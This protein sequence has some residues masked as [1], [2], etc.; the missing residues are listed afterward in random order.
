MGSSACLSSP[1]KR[2]SDGFSPT[3]LDKERRFGEAS[4]R[5]VFFKI[6]DPQLLRW[7]AAFLL[8]KASRGR[9][10]QCPGN[11]FALARSFLEVSPGNSLSRITGCHWP[12]AII[13][14]AQEL[15]RF[16]GHTVMQIL[17]P[18]NTKSMPS[19]EEIVEDVTSLWKAK[20]N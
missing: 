13:Q 16:A 14:Q 1:R 3:A 18:G 2:R 5:F 11:Q 15:S 10:P 19:C 8:R 12:A 7:P 17:A 9:R 6:T 20:E 4:C